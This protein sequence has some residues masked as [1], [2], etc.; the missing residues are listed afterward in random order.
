M[1][2][3]IYVIRSEPGPVKVGVKASSDGAQVKQYG[4]DFCGFALVSD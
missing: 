1:T 3:A 2:R 4:D